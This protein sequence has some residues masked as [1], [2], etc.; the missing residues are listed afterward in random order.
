MEHMTRVATI[1]DRHLYIGKFTRYC[2][3]EQ[4]GNAFHLLGEVLSWQNPEKDN[5]ALLTDLIDSRDIHEVIRKSNAFCG[6]FILIARFGDDVQVFSDAS[7]LREIYYTAD[8]QHLASQVKLL[9]KVTVLEKHDDADAIDFFKSDVFEQRK[10]FVGEQTH[11]KNVFHLRPNHILRLKD[12]RSERFFP[13]Q[14]RIPSPTK[15]VAPQC[16]AMIQGYIKAA[17]LRSSIEMGVTGGYDSRL[18][19]LASLGVDCRYFVRKQET[20]PDDHWEISIPKRL[21][22]HYNRPFAIERVEEDDPAEA[23]VRERYLHDLDFPRPLNTMRLK[24]GRYGI[25]GNVGEI[26]K[27]HFEY[28]SNVT[29]VDLSCLLGY[30][31]H[32]FPVK[33]CSEWI[34]EFET[35]GTLGYHVLDLFYWEERQGNWCAKKKTEG[36]SLNV[37]GMS[38]FN[39]R[40]VMQR[41]LSTPKKDR[42][43]HSS[44]LYD[45]IIEILADGDEVVLSLPINPSLKIRL[46]RFLKKVRL[47]QLYRF[48]ALKMRML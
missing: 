30:A 14:K 11:R 40:D 35:T 43:Q 32:R 34:Q 47:F 36:L 41:M 6:E 29:A 25:N 38:P 7:A 28:H 42:D 23:D 17:S 27:N 5:L 10:L 48:V 4:G 33:M 13:I 44:P 19:F 22:Q 1:R 37:E 31:F 39:S 45:A 16:A 20:M 12:R 18:L 24:K 9:E 2:F 26:A 15:I 8:C 3:V 46:I 21:T